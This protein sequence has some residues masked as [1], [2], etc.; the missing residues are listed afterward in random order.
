MSKVTNLT[1]HTQI[2]L[3]YNIEP[4]PLVGER[5]E[6]YSIDRVK[7]TY[8]GPDE[9]AEHEDDQDESFD[10]D[11]Y[12]RRVLPSGKVDGRQ[13]SAERVYAGSSKDDEAFAASVGIDYAADLAARYKHIGAVA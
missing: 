11:L 8:Y 5:G 12:G 7:V 4:T 2:T 9:T 3:V 6:Q 13:R 10:V 1:V